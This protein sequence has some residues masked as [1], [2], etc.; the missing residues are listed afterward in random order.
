MGKIRD[1]TS[2][3]KKLYKGITWDPSNGPKWKAQINVKGKNKNCGLYKTQKEA[4]LAYDEEARKLLGTDAE[5]NYPK[6][7]EKKGGKRLKWND[8]AKNKLKK[9][10]EK[11]IKTRR[12]AKKMGISQNA[13]RCAKSRFKYDT[14]NGQSKT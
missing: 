11:G 10:V 9:Y 14:Q 4:A 3:R 5:L 13:V 7:D 12:I 6:P 2:Q 8:H 1:W